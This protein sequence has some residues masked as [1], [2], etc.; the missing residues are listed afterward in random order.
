[1][2]SQK[3]SD[4]DPTPPSAIPA[5]RRDLETRVTEVYKMAKDNENAIVRANMVRM[6]D[7]TMLLKE[8]RKLIKVTGQ[9]WG[10]IRQERR[11]DV[12]RKKRSKAR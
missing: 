4:P 6:E 3:V 9:I 10:A 1:M 5:W 2:S 8:V 11:K 12:R 7:H